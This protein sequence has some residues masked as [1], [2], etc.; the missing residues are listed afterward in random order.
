MPKI[1]KEYHDFVIKAEKRQ[2]LLI[3]QNANLQLSSAQNA[4]KISQI[5]YGAQQVK[6]PSQ[7]TQGYQYQG[8]NIGPNRG[9]NPHQNMGIRYHAQG[10]GEEHLHQMH[11][12]PG[13]KLD[14]LVGSIFIN[15][16]NPNQPSNFPPLNKAYQNH[17]NKSQ[18]QQQVMQSEQSKYVNSIIVNQSSTNQK[19]QKNLNDLVMK[20]TSISIIN[21]TNNINKDDNKI[22]DNCNTLNILCGYGFNDQDNNLENGKISEQSKDQRIGTGLSA[23][24][25]KDNSVKLIGKRKTSADIREFENKIIKKKMVNAAPS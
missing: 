4:A 7:N 6:F 14:Q 2:Q 23:L 22:Y 9:Q 5:K 20:N 12:I 18:Q 13:V 25:N 3:T 17:P 19:L 11:N 16:G 8:G 15:Q 1:E 10:G 24:L 21:N